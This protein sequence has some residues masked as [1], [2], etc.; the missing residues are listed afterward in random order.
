MKKGYTLIEVMV[1]VAIFF[2][3]LAAPTGFFIASLKSQM[4]TL[5]SQE[6]L[7][8]TSY[9]LEYI[10]RALR[11]AKKDKNGSCL[12]LNSNY[13]KTNSRTLAGVTYSGPGIKFESYHDTPICQE[14]FLDGNDKVLKESR[15]GAAPLPLTS[16]KLEILSF[17][18]GGEES[19][20]Q[21]DNLQPKV[22]LFFEIKGGKNLK[23]ELQPKMK[24]QTTISQRNL[25]VTY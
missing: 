5:A 4:R 8:Q 19:W 20:E 25:D 7:S 18:V 9:F 23:P 6:L 22:T 10:S 17:N 21:Y 24:I 15:N 11:M 1:A 2:S 3:V 16:G 14:I 12:G 13:M